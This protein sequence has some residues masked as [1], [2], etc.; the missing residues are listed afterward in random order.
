MEEMIFL[1][2]VSLHFGT[3]FS[4]DHIS[5]CV[6]PGE[7]F[8]FLG[9]SGAGKTT[10]IKLLTRQLQKEEGTIRVLG[11]DI[12]S[13]TRDDYDRIGILSD[14]NGLYERMSI[15]ENLL[16]FAR[17]RNISRQDVET[18]LKRMNLSETRKTLIK[19]CSKGMRQRTVLAAAI[20]HKP[21]LLFLDEPTNG[22][23]PANIHEVHMML[24]ELNKSG[25]TIFLTTHNMEEAD[26]LCNR[27]GILNEGRLILT[28]SPEELKL[29]FAQDQ[30]QVL[31]KEKERLT[32]SKD[33]EG[34]QKIMEIISSGQCLTIHSQEPNLEE[35]FL[36]LTGRGL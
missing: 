30:I 34:A 21:T 20:I 24:Q 26:K 13:V 11:K 31:T 6:K 2:N 18:I 25:T 29:K 35:I 14:T 12:S 22:L 28:G 3:S 8:G 9:P 15:E 5:F 4:L 7:V 32:F 23:D 36:Q 16:F 33:R 27:I 19:K 17:I 10:T 1:E